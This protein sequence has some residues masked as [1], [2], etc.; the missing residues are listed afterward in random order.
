[1]AMEIFLSRVVRFKRSDAVRGGAAALSIVI[2]EVRGRK[3]LT[4]RVWQRSMTLRRSRGRE[5][6]PC[7]EKQGA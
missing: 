2:I 6:M 5:R 3:V 7:A 4:F 1:M